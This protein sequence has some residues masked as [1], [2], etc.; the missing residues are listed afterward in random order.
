[1]GPE[2]NRKENGH[3]EGSLILATM[4]LVS[5]S[6]SRLNLKGDLIETLNE[7]KKC[8]VHLQTKQKK[9]QNQFLQKITNIQVK[10]RLCWDLA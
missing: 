6:M 8:L 9:Q 7:V 4:R 5:A 3:L 2:G 10:N 1:M